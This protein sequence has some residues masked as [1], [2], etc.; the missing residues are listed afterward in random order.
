MSSTQRCSHISCQPEHYIPL[1]TVI[2]SEMDIW[3]NQSQSRSYYDL[4][5]GLGKRNTPSSELGGCESKA[6]HGHHIS[7][8]KRICVERSQEKASRAEGWRKGIALAFSLEHWLYQPRLAWSS[9]E[10]LPLEWCLV[11]ESHTKS[12]P[13]FIDMVWIR[14]LSL[15]IE[16]D[17]P[18][19]MI[20]FHA[21]S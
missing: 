6:L 11:G 13:P 14:F 16:G 12:T 18:E 2:G 8:V 4:F 7:H 17:M 3:A 19:N 1:A 9:P 21:I 20:P 10:N 5:I 15:A